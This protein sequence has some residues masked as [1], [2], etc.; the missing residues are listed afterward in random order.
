MRLYLVQHGKSKSA[1]E[2]P[3]R[4]LTTEGRQDAIRMAKF[5]SGLALSVSAIQHSGKTRAEQ[6]ARILAEGVHAERGVEATKG[7]DPLDDPAPLAQFLTAYPEALMLVGHLPHL[8]RLTS[9]L[10]T[11][12]PD[13]RLIQFTNGGVVCLERAKDKTW[14]LCWTVIPE[15]LPS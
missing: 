13:R 6:T 8:E 10:L 7:L 2:D 9:V 4:G 3:S 5:L 15:L 11:G 14:S 12:S 1:E